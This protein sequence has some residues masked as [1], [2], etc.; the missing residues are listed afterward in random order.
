MNSIL[1]WGRAK[2]AAIAPVVCAATSLSFRGGLSLAAF[3]G[4]VFG[5]QRDVELLFLWPAVA[6]RIAHRLRATML[7][8]ND[9]ARHRWFR[10]LR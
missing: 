9:I 5:A 3:L 6:S 7:E 4:R 1:K 8:N 10:A 2:T